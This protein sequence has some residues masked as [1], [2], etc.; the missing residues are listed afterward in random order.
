M[1]KMEKQNHN[2]IYI[3][4]PQILVIF[5]FFLWI[6]KLFMHIMENGKQF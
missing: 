4:F 5:F 2:F 6:L 3:N 1:Y